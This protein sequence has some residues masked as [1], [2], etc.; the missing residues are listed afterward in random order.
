M[1][2]RKKPVLDEREMLEM[3]RIEHAGLWLM[4]AL[5]CI[6]VVVQLLAGA[7]LV[8][9]AGELFALVTVSV[10]MIVAN[11]RQGIW[12]ED[13]RPSTGGNAAC[14]LGSGVCVAAVVAVSRGSAAAGL[15]A[16]GAVAVL[17]F[18]TLTGLMAYMKRRQEKREQ[19]LENE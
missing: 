5:L 16:G 10:V 9:M 4:Y 8:Q 7:A 17:C 1:L 12:D 11:V 15:A 19:A 14:A 2:K 18:L 6:A 13:A 3:Y